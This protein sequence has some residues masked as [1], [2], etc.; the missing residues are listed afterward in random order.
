MRRVLVI[1]LLAAIW[2]GS[3]AA[4][5]A[6]D[7]GINTEQ[8]ID[9]GIN[10]EQR[11]DAR[12]NTEQSMDAG[13]NTEQSIDAG[14]NSKQTILASAEQR[15][16]RG[17]GGDRGSRGGGG[18]RGAD[19]GGDRGGDRGTRTGGG[20][21]RSRDG[22]RGSRGTPNRVVVAPRRPVVVNNYAPYRRGYIYPAY[23]YDPWVRHYYGWSPIRYAPWGWIYGTAGSTAL[24]L[25]YA[26]YWPYYTGYGYSGPAPYYGYAP[27]YSDYSNYYTAPRSTFDTG[28]VRLRVQP[29][30]AQVFVDG[31]YA[32]L[33][34]D[35][36]G[37]FQELRLSQGS[38]RIEVRK[39]GFESAVFD[40]HIQPG[41]TI[42]LRQDLR[43]IP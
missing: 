19:R 16:N 18:D 26:G 14:I 36:D 17:G 12:I 27:G 38:H 5:S 35:F 39:P 33:V 37:V 32:G 11:I 8:R 30:D 31:R 6:Q 42:D 3:P 13:I 7:A 23:R 40:V 20:E 4:A 24:G 22:D 1:P 29:R 15:G 9:A 28:A 41:R 10:T 21:I 2:I 25:G 34:N 43:P